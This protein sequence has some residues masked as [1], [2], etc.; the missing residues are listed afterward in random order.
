M[1][2]DEHTP[3]HRAS[4]DRGAWGAP[5]SLDPEAFNADLADGEPTLDIG[6]YYPENLPRA[7]ASV[8]LHLPEGP[9]R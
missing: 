9:G 7:P 8:P 2:D 1:H 4:A 3:T 6:I 5:A